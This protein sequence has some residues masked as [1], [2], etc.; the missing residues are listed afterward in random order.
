MHNVLILIYHCIDNGSRSLEDFADPFYTVTGKGFREQM[1]LISKLNLRVIKL[2]NL[3]CSILD[4]KPLQQ[5]SL[6][7]TFDDGYKSDFEIAA[8][9]LKEFNLHATFFITTNNVQSETVWDK[10]TE[11]VKNGFS[12][13]SHTLS[14]HYLTKLNPVELRNELCGSKTIIE[15][16]TGQSVNH[17]SLPGGRYNREVIKAAEECGYTSVLTTNVGLNNHLS[18]ARK[19]KRWSV[20]RDTT[21]PEFKRMVQF[22]SFELFKKVSTSVTL[23]NIKN[24]IGDETYTRLKSRIVRSK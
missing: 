9:A 15:Q 11:M 20:K 7:I 2:D 5:D 19:L 18:D 4:R 21:L 6:V 22:D 8:P 17:L 1:E 23:R 24:V 3:I 16:K 10:L 13:G 12:L 14:H